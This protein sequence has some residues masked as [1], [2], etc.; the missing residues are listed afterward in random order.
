M[1]GP[2]YIPMR[3]GVGVLMLLCGVGV[4]VQNRVDRQKRAVPFFKRQSASLFQP[5]EAASRGE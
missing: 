4:F 5:V 1:F 3:D 2:A